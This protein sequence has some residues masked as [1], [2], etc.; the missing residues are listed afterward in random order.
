MIKDLDNQVA[1]LKELAERRKAGALVRGPLT[2]PPVNEELS[3][4][5]VPHTMAITSGKGGVGKTLVTVNLAIQYARQGLKVLL[6]DADLGLANIDVVLGIPSPE[7][8]LQDVLEGHLTLDQVA[9]PGPEGITILPA[10]SGVAGLSSLTEEQKLALMDH[11]DH[12]NA[13]FD[14]VL[15]DTGAGISEN[16]RFFV[17]AVERIMVIATPDPTSVTDA[18]ALMKVLFLNHRASHFDLV[19]N[20]VRD[21]AEAKDVF[22]TL[23]QVADKFLN[24]VLNFVGSIPEDALLAQSVRSQKPVSISHPDAAVSKSFQKLSVS[25]MRLWREKRHEEGRMIFFWRRLLQDALG[26]SGS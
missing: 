19:V 12:W 16:V 26:Q 25:L 23:S 20:Q 8:T 6:I 3:Q 4:R 1:T 2:A 9:V 7:F 11:I 24:I 13:D 15:V 18:Y 5:K 17:L 14:V 10:A 21:E 22:R